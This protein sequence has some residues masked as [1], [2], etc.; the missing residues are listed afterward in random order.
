MTQ[1][2]Q[3][4]DAYTS[5]RF[6]V[7]IEGISHARFQECSGMQAQT[8]VYE[9][10]EGGLNDYSHKLPGRTTYT[11]ITLKRGMTDSSEMWD[12]YMRVVSAKNKAAETKN[13]SIVQ[14]DVAGK[15]AYRWNLTAA[16]PVKWSG[17]NYNSTNSAMNI[18]TFELAFGTMSA[19]SGAV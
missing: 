7:E 8:E 14:Y 1:P 16:F 18:E 17:P 15:E 12:W 4:K 2:G 6:S 5:F 9:Y 19:V 11:N 10:K 13:V 3:T